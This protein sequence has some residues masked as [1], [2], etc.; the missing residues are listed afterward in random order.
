MPS[1]IGQVGGYV[2]NLVSALGGFDA[3]E[4]GSPYVLGDDALGCLRDIKRWL[5]HYD[6]KRDVWDVKAALGSMNVVATDLCPILASCGAEQG[7]DPMTRRIALACVE[8]LVPITWPLE[9]NADSDDIKIRQCPNLRLALREY[10]SAILFD[11]QSAVLGNVLKVAYPSFAVPKHERS[12]RDNG[13]VR[14][15]LYLLRNLAAIDGDARRS[16]TILAFAEAS[17]LDLLCT[18][19]S[20]I[21]DDFT[22]EDVVVLDILYQLFRGVDPATVFDLTRT[23]NATAVAELADLL[24]KEKEM[25]RNNKSKAHTR[26][27]RFGTAVSIVKDE[28][29]YTIPSQSGV[30]A[31]PLGNRLSVLDAAKKWNRPNRGVKSEEDLDRPVAL[32]LDART[33][34]HAALGDFLEAGFNPLFG[35]LLRALESDASRVSQENRRQYLY[36]QSWFLRALREHGKA[37]RRRTHADAD[38]ADDADYR[39]VGIVLDSRAIITLRKM[40]RESIETRDWREAHA[41]LNCLKEVLLTVAAMERSSDREYQEIAENLLGNLFYEEQSLELVA[42]AVRV[43]NN[44]SLGYLDAATDLANVLLKML[45]RY[46]SSK[47]HMYVRSR[48]QRQR[49]KQTPD[50]QPAA[51][52]GNASDDEEAEARAKE[53]VRERAFDFAKF[54]SKFV[55]EHCVDTFTSLLEYYAELSVEQIRRVITFYHRCAVKQ[56]RELLIFRL[57]IFEL[58][59]RIVGDKNNVSA[60]SKARDEVEAFLRH[61]SR[62]FAKN[63]SAAPAL[64]FE[65]LFP[66]MSADMYYLTH[67][68][69][70]APKVKAPPRAPAEL[71]VLSSIDRDQQIRVAVCALLDADRSAWLD[72]LVGRLQ[73]IVTERLSWDEFET[74]QVDTTVLDE[75]GVSARPDRPHFILKPGEEELDKVMFADGRARLLLKL[76]GAARVGERDDH[77]AVNNIQSDFD[78]DRIGADLRVIR[79]CILDPPSFDDG[80]TAAD[81]IR[82]ETKRP[83]RSYSDSDSSSDSSSGGEGS[84]R[85]AEKRPKKARKRV[86][87]ESAAGLDEEELARRR[88]KRR[89]AEEE[90]NAQIKSSKYVHDSDDEDDEAAIA[91]FYARE[92]ELRERMKLKAAGALAAGT[93][94]A[95]KGRQKRKK[96]GARGKK[97]KASAPAR[98]RADSAESEP[99]SEVEAVPIIQPTASSQLFFADSEDEENEVLQPSARVNELS[100]AARN[101]DAPRKHAARPARRLMIDSDDDD[102]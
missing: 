33:A 13:I 34:V 58:L 10:K 98:Q 54:E 82:R 71:K 37:E 29:R 20:G 38:F 64:A 36:M 94:D 67:D 69:D 56:G 27:T 89:E 8:I 32:T 15:V 43:Y 55:N 96:E 88:D 26:H 84:E 61:I 70:R 50:A 52:S 19:A 12:D 25:H 62:R 95:G 68:Q 45:E 73:A 24:S 76:I 48:R 74:L 49:K 40:L 42:T 6:D 72:W 90:R 9:L 1:I 102:E 47:E 93:A 100:E 97:A 39:L 41:A 60:T 23:S 57:D 81:F 59:L 46:S 2:Q 35:S 79:D 101:G 53:L 51:T 83:V 92:A 63:V 91:A 80:K 44:Q 16:E 30:L 7:S 86:R 78:V 22:S 18:L 5:Q 77:E 3:S 65:M 31:D 75:T 21:G 99:E 4:P 14:L 11:S 17:A 66:K 28:R 85:A 87:R